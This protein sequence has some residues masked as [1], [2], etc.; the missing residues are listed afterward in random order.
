[1]DRR[2][3]LLLGA[4]I[5]LVA[6]FSNSGFAQQGAQPAATSG[7]GLEEIVVTARRREER[8]QTVPLAITAFSQAALERGQI[9]EILDLG[10]HVPSVGTAITS[11]DSNSTY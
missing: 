11:S 6:S 5:S 10:T 2:D 7:A 9:H 8:I 3:L 4:A 1:M